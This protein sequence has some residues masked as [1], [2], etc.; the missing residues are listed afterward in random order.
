MKTASEIV[1]LLG[2]TGEVATACDCAPSSVTGWKDNNSIPRWRRK[3]LL[4]LAKRKGVELTEE[5][6]PRRAA[7]AADAA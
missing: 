2:G 7:P 6:F 3:T 5:D 4:Q 1:D